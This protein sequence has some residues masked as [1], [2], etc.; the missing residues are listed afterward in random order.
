MLEIRQMPQGSTIFR[1]MSAIS[2]PKVEKKIGTAVPAVVMRE[3]L[4]Q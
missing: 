1:L 3:V 4:V 2:H